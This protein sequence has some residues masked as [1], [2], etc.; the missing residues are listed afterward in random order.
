MAVKHE[1]EAEEPES[2]RLRMDNVAQTILSQDEQE[3]A[4]G[5]DAF[6]SADKP[7]FT[8]IVKQRYTDFLVNEILPN[9][10]VL[11]LTEIPDPKDFQK[12]KTSKEKQPEN[13]VAEHPVAKSEDSAPKPKLEQTKIPEK[14]DETAPVEI[15]ELSAEDT[16]ILENIFGASVTAAIIKLYVAVLTN[17]KKKPRDHATINSEVISEK[18]QRTQAHVQVRR[19]FNSKLETTTLQDQAG[20]ISVKAA[21]PKGASGARNNKNSDGSISKGK[22][23]WDELGGEYLH[24]TL[25]KE[26]KDTME[27]LVFMGTQLKIPAKNFQFAGTKDR[28]GVTVQRV[29]IFRVEA[30]RIANLNKLAKGW[31]AGGFKYEKH[32][33]ELGELTG[34]EFTLTLRD[35]HFPN[36]QSLNIQAR[37][38]QAKTLLHDAA[39]SFRARGFLNYYGLQRFGSFSI[40]THEVG[41]KMLKGDL[42]GAVD[43]ILSYSPTILSED[44]DKVP[45]DDVT[46][47][48]AIKIWRETREL[49]FLPKRFQ[50]ETS[51]MQYLCKKGK[52]GTQIQERDYQGALMTITRN[53]RLMYVHAYQSF[54]WN[55]IATRR[56][57]QFG[58][59]V[60]EGDLVVIGEKDNV[61]KEVQDTVDADGEPIFH[62]ADHDS[63]PTLDDFTRARALSKEE[64]ESGR[65]DVFDLVLP[66][67]G[68]DVIY[69]ANEIGKL[70]E[71]FMASPEGGGLDPHNMRRAWKD[72]SLSGGYRKIMSRP[73]K[74]FHAEV[75]L[76]SDDN[77]Q[78]VQTDLEKLMAEKKDHTTGEAPETAPIPVNVQEAEEKL[79]VILKFQLG[80]SQYA[81]MA[82]RELTKSGAVAYKPEFSAQR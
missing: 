14:T 12:N 28:R 51:I 20:V 69:P 17:P 7:G 42:G 2:K 43:S 57:A 56:W 68:F 59:R 74:G 72:I 47:A 54:V 81:T 22:V 18:S 4:V 32:G 35:C 25:H 3:K 61:G 1:L 75:K 6:V 52:T 13:S 11:H 44:N 26:N 31:R 41:M 65:F 63:A 33:L 60:V 48:R 5:I 29:A 16:S 8:C 23:I 62:P 70:Y 78:L 66:L 10:T 58:D 9:G 40:G 53:L 27:V 49:S 21:P 19:I 45:V 46:R 76:Y 73:G 50:A 38:E 37:F 30:H 77:E 24:F 82:L 34:N 64:A 39:E 67:P 80:S 79:A 55:T 71:T 15:P 36:D